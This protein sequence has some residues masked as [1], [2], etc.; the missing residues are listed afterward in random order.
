MAVKEIE[1]L[2][3]EFGGLEGALQA[4]ERLNRDIAYLLANLDEWRTKYPN[5]WV[6]VYDGEL[7]VLADS[8]ES[9]L[10]QMKEKGIPVRKAVIDFVT[11]KRANFIL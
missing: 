4:Q 8:S 2:R 5:R 6:A 11:E 1:T 9:L 10:E 7:V 3:K